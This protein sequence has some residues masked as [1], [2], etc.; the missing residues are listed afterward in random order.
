[1]I[2]QTRSHTIIL[3]TLYCTIAIVAITNLENIHITQTKSGDI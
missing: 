2:K 1:M 3:P